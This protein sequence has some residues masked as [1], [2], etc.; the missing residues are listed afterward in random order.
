MA[1]QEKPLDPDAGPVQEFAHA[2]R[3]VRRQAGQPTYRVMAQRAGYSPSTLSEAAAGERL[4]SL[5]V[6]L[7]YVTACGAD[8]GEWEERWR[9]TAAVV[10]ARL[11]PEDAAGAPYRGL[12]RYEPADAALFF[13][14]DELVGDLLHTVGRE[15]FTALAGPSGS[16]KS[17][18]LRAGLLPALQHGNATRLRLAALRILAPG[19]HPARTHATALVAKDDTTGDTVVVVDQFEELFT[20]CTDPAERTEFLGRLLAAREPGSRLRVVIAVRADFLGR[21]AEHAPLATA[22]RGTLLLVGP[23]SRD[24]LRQAIVGPAQAAG[25]IVERSLTARLL[26]ETDGRPGGL[27]LMSHALLETWRRRQGRRLTE[28]AYEA[29]GG[30]HGAIARTAED[31][32]TGLTPAQAVQAR[33]L[34]LRL[35]TPGDGTPDTRRPAPRTELDFGDRSDTAAVLEHLTRARLI[36]CDDTTVDLAHEALITAW[37]RLSAWLDTERDRLRIHRHLTE[38]ATAWH[39]LEHDPGA[40]YRGTRLDAAEEAFPATARPDDLTP[41]ENTFLTASTAARD[42]ERRAARAAARRLRRF[43]VTVSLLLAVA[44]TAGAIAWKQQRETVA[45]QRTN[46]SWRLAAQ[47]KELMRNNPDLASLLALHA[48]QAYATDEAVDSLRVAAAL[49]HKR[50]LTEDRYAGFRVAL[51]P[52]GHTMATDVSKGPVRLWDVTTRK[53]LTALPG[54]GDV[55]SVTFGPD[56]TLATADQKGPVRLWDVTTRKKLTTLPDTDDVWSVTFGPDGTLATIDLK[57]PVRLW[58]VT[59][60]KKLTTLPDTDDVWSVTF[61]PDGTLATIDQEG[62][63]R[64]WDVTTR[65]K[66]TTL[67]DTDDVYSMTFAPDGT[68]ATADQEGSVHLWNVRARRELASLPDDDTVE[69]A[70]S[71]DGRTLAAGNDD[72]QIRL[73]DTG[74]RRLRA[75]LTGTGSITSM[76][77]GPAGPAGKILVAGSMDDVQVWDTD[78]PTEP[79][80]AVRTICRA[81]HRELTREERSSYLP[82]QPAHHPCPGR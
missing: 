8:P 17:S 2:L 55:W 15:P 74:T 38:A 23:M 71:P 58:D 9:V 79:H 33:S 6:T 28:A 7:A 69:V 66:L 57:G 60:R 47:S 30:L 72:G 21:C 26:A 20:L 4:P 14:R 77:F 39:D 62:P 13:G 75:T 41:L 36:T 43:A 48:Y 27:P 19:P 10:A 40:L 64:L 12:A 31:C 16:G 46:L 51:S 25:L 34:L 45:A 82:G 52:D 80:E 76:V 5:A 37:P 24:E 32:Y 11:A 1:R 18:L 29:A 73:Y 70:S 67:P 65:K 59:T 56:G 63:V 3:V 49:P 81:V 54:T 61:G 42:R 22:L 44:L 78:V 50:L 68:L 35:I 53:A